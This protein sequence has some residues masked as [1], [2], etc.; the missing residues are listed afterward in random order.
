MPD[1]DPSFETRLSEV[2]RKVEVIYQHIAT[3]AA[4]RLVPKLK[5]TVT[6]QIRANLD[7]AGTLTKGADS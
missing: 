1:Q 5:E 7:A 3:Q 6:K 2:E 4:E